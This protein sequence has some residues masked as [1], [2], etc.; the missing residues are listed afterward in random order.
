MD[1]LENNIE[2]ILEKVINPNKDKEAL[3][4]AR[5]G[6]VG[7]KPKSRVPKNHLSQM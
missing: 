4:I 5:S 7:N 2:S 3:E 1:N 6:E